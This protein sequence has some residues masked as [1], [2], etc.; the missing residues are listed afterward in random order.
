MSAKLSPKHQAFVT[1]YLKDLNAT[2]AYQSVYKCTEAA[3]AVNASKLL[4]NAKVA[5]AVARAQEKAADK[6]ALT[7]QA[8]LDRLEELSLAAEAALQYG[9]AI[10]SEELRG[11]VSGFYVE[12][13]EHSG[14]IDLSQDERERAVLGILTTARKR[15]KELVS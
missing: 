15:Q 3:A 6:A 7:L 4:R 1:A 10:K 14:G 11:K 2:K 13:V 5:S 9:A 12:K 8:H